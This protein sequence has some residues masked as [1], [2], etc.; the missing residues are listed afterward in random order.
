MTEP[1]LAGPFQAGAQMQ[2]STLDVPDA[3]IVY[4]VREPQS[5]T[6]GRP[7]LVLI[8]QP[9]PAA[10]FASLAAQF[11]D[12]TVV[13]YDPR[14]LGRSTRSDGTD[15]QTPE[16]QADDL[17]A[18]VTALGG[19]PVD[20]F[21]SSGGA[22]T[23]LAWVVRHP[24]DVRTLVAHEPPIIPILPDADRAAAAMAA[25]HRTY[26]QRGRGAGMA[27][28]IAV[29]SHQGEYGPDFAERP[30]PDPAM[31][32]MP[33]EDDG[34]RDDPLLS[35]A[36]VAISG[37]QPDVDALRAASA[38][39]V[40]ALGKE[41]AGTMPARA[42]EATALAIGQQPTTFPGNHGGFF[43]GEFGQQGDPEAFGVTLREVL[44]QPR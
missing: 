26:A 10:G 28:F 27:H 31:F 33:T 23:G 8:G 20:V 3:R 39:V 1:E 42:A 5:A 18:V 19:G 9:M 6:D 2:T 16:Q 29:A 21:G 13:T 4:D 36:A 7:T 44:D 11:P 41:S 22:V 34:S 40:L 30:A 17:H 24:Q 35:E 25:V 37:Y 14:G 15:T 38:R 43:G 32:G 12:R